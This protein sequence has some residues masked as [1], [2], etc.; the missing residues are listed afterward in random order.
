MKSISVCMITYNKAGFLRYSIPALF[1]SMTFPDQIEVLVLDNGST[2]ETVEV[3]LEMIDRYDI[4]VYQSD[5]NVGLNGYS[6]LA[7]VAGGDMI[8]TYD[9]DVFY[10]SRGWEERFATALSS[11]FEG[12]KVGYVGSRPINHDS[13]WNAEFIIGIAESKNITINIAPVGGWFA[14]TS[15][16]AFE[17]CGGFH[18]GHETMH[19]DDLD[20]QARIRQ[21]G[22]IVGV[23]DD[24]MVIHLRSPK[25]Y[26]ILGC[27][28][29]YIE[30]M[31]LAEVEGFQLES[32]T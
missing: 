8:V 9:D 21:S 23:L 6:D 29:M 32:I 22:R 13:G 2:D 16:S 25:Y 19:L 20:Y 12:I 4:Q 27:T 5:T 10:V 15:R 3:L 14:A 18:S 30:K 31:K 7:E 11:T 1:K 28:N 24:V 17:E 26:K